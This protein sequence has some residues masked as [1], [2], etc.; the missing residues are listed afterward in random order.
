MK[1]AC[2]RC[3]KILDDQNSKFCPNCGCV[4]YKEGEK[5]PYIPK[6]APKV[7][8]KRVVYSNLGF[9]FSFLVPIV[10]FIF[11]LIALGDEKS[12]DKYMAILGLVII[13]LEVFVGIMLFVALGS[14]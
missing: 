14:R 7:E 11:C 2:G 6:P 3:G 9:I 5:P 13:G 10:G 4:L 1:F 12:K 8:E